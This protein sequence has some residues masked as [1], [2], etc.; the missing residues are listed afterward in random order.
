[1]WDLDLGE[2]LATFRGHYDKVQSVAFSPDDRTLATAGDDSTVRVWDV[3]SGKL[4]NILRGSGDRVWC[5]AFSPDGKTLAVTSMNGVV[6]TWDPVLRQDCLP[7]L[8]GTK[9]G[10][11]LAFSPDSTQLLGGA[12]VFI[13]YWDT[14][15]GLL[16]G[17]GS[18]TP[19]ILSIAC[20]P[21][22]GTLATGHP[23]GSIHFWDMARKQHQ[24]A[25]QTCNAPV[26][27]LV[28]AP[29]GQTLLTVNGGKPGIWDLATGQSKTVL[30]NASKVVSRFAVSPDG[31]TLAVSTYEP[32]L[33]LYDLHTGHVQARWPIA[34]IPLTFSPDG[35]LLAVAAPNATIHL[36]D[37]A[38]GTPRS[39]LLGHT[40]GIFSL[41]F[42]PDGKTLASGSH[43][44]TARL[45]NVAT[46]QEL[47]TLFDGQAAG[48]VEVAFSP[49]GR[50]LAT[51]GRAAAESGKVNLWLT[52]DEE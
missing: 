45:W 15:T 10:C 42:T 22:G 33:V 46:G 6:R 21:D 38:T 13:H 16:Q 3:R 2:E 19:D 31:A 27:S 52:A 4:R 17:A 8:G 35:T 14:K 37:V 51:A 50:M 20:S 39:A 9:N 28:F 11:N 25:I 48:I 29:D 24:R 7:L 32:A 41:S 40:D 34:D 5:A 12:G 44:G 23:D 47:F 36:W 43:D 49:D 18:S 1:L 26:D 30:E